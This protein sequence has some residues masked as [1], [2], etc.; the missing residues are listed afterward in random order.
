MRVAGCRQIV[1]RSASPNDKIGA[2]RGTGGSQRDPTGC[3]HP[4]GDEGQTILPAFWSQ[5][6]CWTDVQSGWLPEAVFRRQPHTHRPIHTVLQKSGRHDKSRRCEEGDDV[7]PGRANVRVTCLTHS[8]AAI[9]RVPVALTIRP[10]SMATGP[11]DGR[12]RDRLSEVRG[13]EYGWPDEV[14]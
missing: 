2:E 1:R 12:T 5:D 10:Y 8:E 3:S 7:Q 6:V 11:P 9:Q 13:D 14:A 4:A